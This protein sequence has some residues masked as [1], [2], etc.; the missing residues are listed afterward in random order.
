MKQ[1]ARLIQHFVISF[2]PQSFP[3]PAINIFFCLRRVRVAA[4][5]GGFT[6]DKLALLPG[7]EE[8]LLSELLLELETRQG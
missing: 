2:I 7:C 5:T 4:S 6:G 8:V 1:E 3:E